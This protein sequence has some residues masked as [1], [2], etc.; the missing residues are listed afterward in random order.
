[1]RLQ[2]RQLLNEIGG[3]TTL[4]DDLG[5]FYLIVSVASLL[6][7]RVALSNRDKSGSDEFALLVFG[8]MVM[9]SATG[10]QFIMD[11]YQGSAAAWNLLILG[12]DFISI[13]WFLFAVE[14][15]NWRTV[16]RY[17][18]A[19]L[20]IEVLIMQALAWTNPSHHLALLPESFVDTQGFHHEVYGPVFWVHAA[21]AYLIIF[22]SI[23]LLVREFFDSSGVRREQVDV[24]LGSISVPLVL[25]LLY[26]FRLQPLDFTLTPVGF[27]IA[28]LGFAWALYHAGFLDL[29]PIARQTAIQ[30]MEDV[31]VTLDGENRVVDHN[32]AA[33]ELFDVDGRVA[34]MP[35][36]EFF[37]PY[38]DIVEQLNDST[39]IE[40]ELT[41]NHGEEPRH[42]HLSISPVHG[43]AER[44][45]S[46]VIVLSNI[47]SLKRREQELKRTTD[48]LDEFAG[49]VSHD[50]RNP[51]NVA[52]G[53]LELARQGCDSEH[54]DAV[55]A[56]HT[57]METL[58]EDLLT[59]ARQGQS[60]DVTEPITLSA[61]ANQCWRVVDTR[62]ATLTVEN[63]LTFMADT[64]RFQQLLENLFGNAIQH[65]SEDATIRVGALEDRPGFYVADDGSG[66][67]EEDCDTVFD[68]G[69]STADDGTGFGLAI[70]S[71]IADAHGW[72]ITVTESQE[73][74]ARFEIVGIDIER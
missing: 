12:A 71:E 52:S 25:N 31:F 21:V 2:N 69:Y 63:D 58:I 68:S 50:L 3:M 30:K 28:E 14:F 13:G 72:T 16:P 33:M 47:T 41:L 24:F 73:G 11:S 36:S 45:T 49:I 62:V 4:A 44:G 46:H 26:V 7:L 35:A 29:V 18:L 1:M 61:V 74:G 34:G 9:G 57:R 19:V 54:L 22:V 59:L 51:L 32:D 67:P 15:T 6:I 10:V 27:F 43:G 23:V 20:G 64:E 37:G 53:H 56:A 40:T 39:D 5:V 17:V 70:V 8:I 66:I 65:G 55:H 38:S 48:R 42:Y 60:I